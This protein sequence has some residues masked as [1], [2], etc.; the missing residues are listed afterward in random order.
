MRGKRMGKASTEDLESKKRGIFKKIIQLESDYEAGDVSEN[1][2]ENLRSK[3]RK[4]VMQL[5]QLIDESRLHQSQSQQYLLEQRIEERSL[6]S[7]LEKLEEDFK[8]GLISE[9]GYQKIKAMYEKRMIKVI[10]EIRKLEETTNN[11]E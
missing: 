1:R 7:T 6:M 9:E 5:M 11:G 8:N 4:R 3:Y 2:Y 10:E